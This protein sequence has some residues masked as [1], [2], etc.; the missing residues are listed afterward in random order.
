MLNLPPP[1]FLITAL[2]PLPPV[3]H[4]TVGKLPERKELGWCT[5]GHGG[6]LYNVDTCI[7]FSASWSS[8]NVAVFPLHKCSL[9][10]WGEGTDTAV[11]WTGGNTRITQHFSLDEQDHLPVSGDPLRQTTRRAPQIQGKCHPLTDSL[12]TWHRQDYSFHWYFFH[13]TAAFSRIIY[14]VYRMVKNCIMTSFIIFKISPDIRSRDCSVG[15]TEVP[16]QT[17]L[18]KVFF[19]F[20]HR[21]ETESGSHPAS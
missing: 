5:E 9:C 6:L 2:F 1:S 14:V 7:V 13:L 18:G 12:G 10:R 3:P 4:V 21:L 17:G 15:M 20:R 19:F 11:A 8:Y 16:L